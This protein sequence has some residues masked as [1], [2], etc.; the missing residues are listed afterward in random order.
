M[1]GQTVALLAAATTAALAILQVPPCATCPGPEPCMGSVTVCEGSPTTYTE[2][3]F[4]DRFG[5]MGSNIVLD[6]S[7][8]LLSFSDVQAQPNS[9]KTWGQVASGGCS[10]LGVSCV[11]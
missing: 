6:S 8:S 11:S 4:K 3:K 2:V 1:I 7:T 10:N 5:Q 9:G